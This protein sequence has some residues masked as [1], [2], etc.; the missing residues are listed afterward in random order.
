M[1]LQTACDYANWL[2]FRLLKGNP[3]CTLFFLTCKLANSAISRCGLANLHN[4][5]ICR[6]RVAP[7][8]G[9]GTNY[10]ALTLV[11]ESIVLLVTS[12]VLFVNCR[13]VHYQWEWL[14]RQKVRWVIRRGASWRWVAM[15]TPANA[16][17]ATCATASQPKRKNFAPS[18]RPNWRVVVVVDEYE[19]Y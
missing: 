17:S 15:A 3:C 1:N 12:F 9:G 2:S 5:P 18:K 4:H 13:R 8:S 16:R 14:Q 6:W 10:A 11:N 19:Y 7:S